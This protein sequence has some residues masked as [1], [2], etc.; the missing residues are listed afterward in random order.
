MLRFDKATYLPL[1]FKIILSD[2]LKVNEDQMFCY[3]QNS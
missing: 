3:A 1:L 2:R